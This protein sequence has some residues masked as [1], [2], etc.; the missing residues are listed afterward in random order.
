MILQRKKFAAL[1]LMFSSCE[2]KRH[3]ILILCVKWQS[4]HNLLTKVIRHILHW[5]IRL[6]TLGYYR[7]LDFVTRIYYICTLSLQEM[8]MPVRVHILFVNF[9]IAKF[10]LVMR[11]LEKLYDEPTEINL[12]KKC[13][14]ICKKEKEF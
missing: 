3:F 14:L 2:V 13:H 8:Q 7:C 5:A 4:G 6:L 12:A 9:H 10:F 11:M 1:L